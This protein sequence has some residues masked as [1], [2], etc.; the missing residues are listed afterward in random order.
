M[1]KKNMPNKN[2]LDKKETAGEEPCRKTAD[3]KA[4]RRRE[5]SN[6]EIMKCR[7]AG[8]F[9]KYS[10]EEMI[11]K[12]SLKN[13]PD[14]LYIRF[15]SRRYRIGRRDGR[16]E[17]EMGQR[18]ADANNNTAMTIQR[19]EEADHNEAMTTQR[20]EEA[21]YNEAMTIYDVLCCS[22]PFC[23]L[24]GEFVNMRSLSSVQGSSAIS[25]SGFFDRAIA[26]FDGK[27]AALSYACEKLCGVKSGRGDVSYQI[28]MFSFFPVIF[29]FW[30]SDEEFPPVL[31]LLMDRNALQ[32]MHYETIW[33][34]V[35]HLL[36]RLK[37]EMRS[38]GSSS[39]N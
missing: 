14:Y 33:F 19:Y 11:R 31:Q 12:F 24:S 16:A 3:I 10:Q 6:Y 37:E 36:N 39:E 28:P 5:T 20:Y 8:E 34:A 17:R 13:D 18:H 15:L 2:I 29:Q 35:S 23:R 27:D 4:S 26:P 7:M 1:V 38:F 30:N 22:K 9:L 21:D 32:Y 25:D